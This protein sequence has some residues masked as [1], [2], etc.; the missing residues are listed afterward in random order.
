[1]R[2]GKIEIVSLIVLLSIICIGPSCREISSSDGND[3]KYS[4][5][6]SI[7]LKP[8]MFSAGEKV[9]MI[10]NIG[11]IDKPILTI[12]LSSKNL[13]IRGKYDL[14]VQYFVISE[15]EFDGVYQMFVREGW[16]E[17]YQDEAYEFGS[18]QY[19]YVDD[20]IKRIFYTNRTES[21]IV[22][23]RIKSSLAQNINVGKA[24]EENL[25]RIREY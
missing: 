24:L 7:K 3:S 21:R 10:E 16:F 20:Q 12:I 14:D 19:I 17:K 23:K 18:F 13:E 15:D 25:Y 5:F 6:D 9:I 11:D 1:M 22:L 2:A 4:E 8:G